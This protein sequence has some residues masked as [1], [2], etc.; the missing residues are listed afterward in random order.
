MPDQQARLE[1]GQPLSLAVQALQLLRRMESVL[2]AEPHWSG[3]LP[4][5]S[6]SEELPEAG[7]HPRANPAMRQ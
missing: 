7:R 6:L 2:Q 3:R 5:L 1:Q 4:C